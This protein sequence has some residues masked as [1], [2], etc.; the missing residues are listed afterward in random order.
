MIDKFSNKL[1]KRKPRHKRAFIEFPSFKIKVGSMESE[2]SIVVYP[3]E[4]KKLNYFSVYL[5]RKSTSNSQNDIVVGGEVTIRK[6]SSFC[7]SKPLIRK[8][9][10]SCSN[11]ISAGLISH[12]ELLKKCGSEPVKLVVCVNIELSALCPTLFSEYKILTQ[13]ENDS[14]I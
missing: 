13:L 11:R 1:L 14:K 10:K 6:A 8:Q 12:E 5:K 4:E 3:R 7:C 2:W 9:F